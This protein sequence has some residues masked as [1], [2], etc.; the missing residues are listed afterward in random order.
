MKK[1]RVVAGVVA[2]CLLVPL[3]AA[4][5]I[6]VAATLRVEPAAEWGGRAAD[7]LISREWWFSQNQMAFITEDWRYVFDRSHGLILVINTRD[8][9]FVEAAMTAAPRDLVEPAYLEALGRIRANGATSKSPF[10]K[11]VL[12]REC[13]GTVISEWLAD[14]NLHFFD[15]DRTVYATADVP[16]DWRLNRDLT[17]W[18]VSFFNPEMSYFGGLRSIE[19][20]PLAETDIYIRKGQRINYG[21]EVKNIREAAPPKGLY[22]V[23]AGFS[24]REKLSKADLLAMRQIVYLAYSF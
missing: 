15:R 13:P 7:I 10:K 2:G 17:V 12:G 14:D 19:G 24:R 3:I 11:T 6:R 8:Q 21:S 4:A 18:M 20:F 9:Y 5:D 1:N 16:F 23:P 22:E